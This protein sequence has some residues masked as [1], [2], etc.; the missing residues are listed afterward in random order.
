MILGT[1]ASLS[2]RLGSQSIYVLLSRQLTTTK[3]RVRVKSDSSEIIDACKRDEMWWNDPYVFADCVDLATSIG[4]ISFSHSP[5]E[6]NGVAHELA[7]FCFSNWYSCSWFDEHPRFLL[8]S[9]INDVTI[10]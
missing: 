3:S 9:M 7:R 8:D 6:A 4:D 1:M 5:R 2:G 10:S